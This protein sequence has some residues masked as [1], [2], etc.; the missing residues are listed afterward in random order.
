MELSPAQSRRE[1]LTAQPDGRPRFLERSGDGR[2]G[3]AQ[4]GATYGVFAREAIED[5]AIL[6][7][8]DGAFVDRPS[9]YSIQIEEHVHVDLPLGEGPTADPDRHPWRYL[10][11]S[12][13]P[14]AAFVGV[15]LIATR[16][17]G[18][19][20]EVTYDYNTTEYDM[21]APFTCRCGTCGGGLVRGFRHL[22]AR[23]RLDLFPRLAEHLRR[24]MNNNLGTL[25]SFPGDR[26]AK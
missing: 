22:P 9:R 5:G 17:I 18:P 15:R 14:N 26:D 1:T 7:T 3:V 13:D 6:M 23:R 16:P 19:E 20:E 8:I 25:P 21:A 10:N 24:R 2:I 4:R 11:H 12:C